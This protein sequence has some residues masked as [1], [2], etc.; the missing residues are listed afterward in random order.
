MSSETG[1]IDNDFCFACGSRNAL[2]LALHFFSEGEQLCTR[3]SLGPQWQGWQ[4][5]AHGGIVATILDDLMSNHLFRLEGIWAVTAELSLRYRLPVP[6]SEE[7]QFTSTLVSRQ[8]RIWTLRGDC[9]TL[10][11][12]GRVLSSATGRFMQF[13]EEAVQG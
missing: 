2:G 10:A 9:R 6:L 7:L 1:W 5:V 4:G 13:G 12:P 11:Q 3:M 8:G